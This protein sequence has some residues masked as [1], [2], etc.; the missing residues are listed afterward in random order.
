M[1]RLLFIKVVRDLRS[2]WPRLGLMVLAMGVTLVMFSGVLYTWS[3]T[4]RELPRAYL[5]TNPASATILF[6]HSQDPEAMARI[7]ARARTEPGVIAAAARTQLT[8][9]VQEDGG[10]WGPNPLQVFVA[11]PDDPMTLETLAVERG[12]WPPAAGAI[13]VSR[14]SFDLLRI[15]VGDTVVVQAPDGQPRSLRVSG[16]AYYPALAPS[17]QEQKGHGFMSAATLPLLGQSAAM[18]ALKIQVGDSPGSAVPTRNRQTIATKAT[19]LANLLQRDY[20]VSVR[21]IRIPTPYAHPH[22]GQADSLMLGLLAFGVAGLLLSAVLVATM[23]NSLMTQHIPQIGIMKAVGAGADRVFWLYLVMTLAIAVPATALAI[24]PGIVISRLLSPSILTLLGVY[25]DNQAPPWWTYVIVVVSGVG[26]PVLFSLASVIK[27]SGMTVREA[28]D[29]RGAQLSEVA[30]AV[31]PGPRWLQHRDRLAL[32]A[33]RNIFRRRAR[34]VLSVS[35]LAGAGAVFVA[36]TSEMAGFQAA[37][38]RDEAL[39]RWDVDVQLADHGAVEADALTRLA[40]AIPGVTYAEPG[41]MIQTSFIPA[42]QTVSITRTYPDEGH[43]SVA[44]AVIPPNSTLI[45]PP[46]MAEGRWLDPA[47]TDAVVIGRAAATAE[48]ADA[49]VGDTIQLA[50]GERFTSWNVVGVADASGHGG[51]LSPGFFITR[52]GLKAATGITGPNL[53]R[54]V[55]GNHDE[56]TRAEVATAAERSL[57]DAGIAV[58]SAAS[59][60]RSAAAGAGH[61]L[62]LILVFL[63]LS[64][65]MGVVGVAGLSSTMSTNV[66]ERTREFGVMSAIGAPGSAVRRLVVL[67]G[68]FIAAMSCVVAIVPALILAALMNRALPFSGPFTISIGGVVIWIILVTLGAALATLLPA[69]RASRLTVREALVYL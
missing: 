52:E 14:T 63:G 11:M 25:A 69:N 38:D 53:L 16:E 50:I 30:S 32:M 42:G 24:V 46:P 28:L 4:S 31:R 65:A 56:E 5:S 40:T 57:S 13:L 43:G 44:L 18:D 66:F 36:G 20:G 54:L 48:L 12:A 64:I 8:L 19:E 17:F 6:E 37:L 27:A 22:Q 67:E 1:T 51:G 9:Q 2:I 34:L 47:D 59:V 7:V 68:M 60:G 33:F 21:E 26:V 62:P 45:A 55:T 61:M 39:R 3:V 23:F 29:Y 41:S 35:L 15:R 49:K 10:T 58:R